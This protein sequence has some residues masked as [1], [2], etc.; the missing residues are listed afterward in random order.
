MDIRPEE[1]MVSIPASDLP[2]IISNLGEMRTKMF[3][4]QE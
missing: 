1:I 2:R 4:K 3:F